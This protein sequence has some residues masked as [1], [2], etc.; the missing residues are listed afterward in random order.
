MAVLRMGWIL[1]ILSEPVT[2]GFLFGAAIDVVVGEPPKSTRTG[3]NG[4]NT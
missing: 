4:E 3:A 1:Q 2:T